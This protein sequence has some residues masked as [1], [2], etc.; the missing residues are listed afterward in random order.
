V[1]VDPVPPSPKSMRL[2][3]SPNPFN[4]AVT[5]EFV[6]P[7]R[8]RAT[9]KVYDLRGQHVVTLQDGVVEARVHRVTWRGADANGEA[10]ASGVYLAV[11]RDADGRR[12]TSKVALIR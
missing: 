10:V 1:A 5:F 12:R 7:V 8:G 3:A 2:V 6:V 4:P 9:L 11:L